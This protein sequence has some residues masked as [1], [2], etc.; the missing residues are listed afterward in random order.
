[1]FF[2]S[3]QLTQ[4]M[5]I[6]RVFIQN[7][8]F[9]N[10]LEVIRNTIFRLE[11]RFLHWKCDFQIGNRIFRLETR[12]LDQKRDFQIRNTIFTLETRFLDWKQDFQT[13]NAI[14]RLET[15]FFDRKQDFYIGNKIF[16]LET[17]LVK[18]IFS[19]HFSATVEITKKRKQYKH[20]HF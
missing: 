7:D 18:K 4:L 14:F 5:L 11:T 8:R 19:W 13:E 15:G 1:M 2:Y 17:F 9:K 12:F 6:S 10:F 20:K 16:N 3:L